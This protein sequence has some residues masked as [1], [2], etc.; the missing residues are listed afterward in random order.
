MDE[1]LNGIQPAIGV[2]LQARLV[3][4]GDKN[5]KLAPIAGGTLNGTLWTADLASGNDYLKYFESTLDKVNPGKIDSG[6]RSLKTVQLYLRSTSLRMRWF[7]RL[8]PFHRA[9]AVSFMCSLFA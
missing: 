6:S 1:D 5:G 3:D 4:L 9:L 8:P 7:G 2:L